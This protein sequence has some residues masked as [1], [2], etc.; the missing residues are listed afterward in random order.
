MS[1]VGGDDGC[2]GEDWGVI[3]TTTISSSLIQTFRQGIAAA[4]AIC[5]WLREVELKRPFARRSWVEEAF[6]L[7]KLG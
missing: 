3:E 7:D 2:G 1:T 5:L 4:A 6:G